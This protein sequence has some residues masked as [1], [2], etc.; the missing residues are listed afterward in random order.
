[1]GTIHSRLFNLFT[2]QQKIKSQQKP[3]ASSSGS[4]VPATKPK[5]T[6][7]QPKTQLAAKEVPDYYGILA[8]KKTAT[9]DEIR[10]NYRQ[11]ALKWHPDRNMHQAEF[12]AKEFQKIAEAYEVLSDDE[13]RKVYDQGGSLAEACCK[14]KLQK[15]N[16]V[17]ED[18]EDDDDE[19]EEEDEEMS[20]R[21]PSEMYKEAMGFGAGA[22]V[23]KC[24]GGAQGS[25]P[26]AQLRKYG[27]VPNGDPNEDSED[28]DDSDDYGSDEDYDSEDYED[29]EQDEGEPAKQE[30]YS[31]K[32][33][34][35][36]AN[37]GA[38]VVKKRKA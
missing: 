28:G 17:G 37:D 26:M 16:E 7:T 3:P 33:K 9:W 12:A 29:E 31:M 19:E 1:M 2:M 32:R 22:C 30:E 24:C 18:E 35:N 15:S 20:F 27:K 6:A 11:L 14:R 4:R 21:D 38:P 34:A 13:L 25:D 36:N 8:V 10:R 5:P 23:T